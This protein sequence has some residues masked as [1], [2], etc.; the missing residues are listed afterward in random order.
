M[1]EAAQEMQRHPTL[2]KATGDIVVSATSED[3][4][5]LFRV[6]TVIL[7]EHSPVFAG[8]L[9]LPKGPDVDMQTYDGVPVVHLPDDAKDVESLLVLLYSPGTPV[10][11]DEWSFAADAY[12]L[13]S[14]AT[15]YQVD[16]ICAAVTKHLRGQWP[17]TLDAFLQKR[18]TTRQ[19]LSSGP[20]YHG[21]PQQ[22]PDPAS[23]IRLAT[24]FNIPEILPAV[25]YELSLLDISRTTAFLTMQERRLPRWDLLRPE[26][27]LR[28]YQGKF[29]LAKRSEQASQVFAL[30]N[31]DR[32]ETIFD[33]YEWESCDIDNCSECRQALARARDCWGEKGSFFQSARGDPIHRLLKMYDQLRGSELCEP[34]AA[35]FRTEC[36]GRVENLWKSLPKIFS[37]EGNPFFAP[38]PPNRRAHK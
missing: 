18:G 27:L 2:Y 12:G 11:K 24:D 34:C 13:M 22:T 36:K 4:T 14:I 5:H 37:L 9:T 33:D 10:F 35:E 3:L 17:S 19:S 8:M 26:E 29:L 38:A 21:I 7:A 20:F 6:H 23:A 1:S 25:Y 16:S 30:D 32:C 15:K 28:Y 31:E